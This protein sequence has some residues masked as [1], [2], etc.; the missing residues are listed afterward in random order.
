MQER[1][2]VNGFQ[3]C[4]QGRHN[5]VADDLLFCS[6]ASS[7]SL[8]FNLFYSHGLTETGLSA[9]LDYHW[10]K[11]FTAALHCSTM[12]CSTFFFFPSLY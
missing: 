6:L 1:R 10:G 7:H 9:M 11:G 2:R 4:P 8:S 12:F 3:R 5:G